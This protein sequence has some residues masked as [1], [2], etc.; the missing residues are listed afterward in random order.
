MAFSSDTTTT[1]AQKEKGRIINVTHQ[2]PYEISLK[3]GSWQYLPR[4]GHG[5]MYGGI[6]SLQKSWDIVY[7]GWTGLINNIVDKKEFEAYSTKEPVQNLSKAE[8]ATLYNQ[9]EENYS[10]IPL[11]FDSQSVSGH[12]DGYCKTSKLFELYMSRIN[13]KIL[14]YMI[15]LWP[16]FHYMIWNDATDGRLESKQWE[17]YAAVNQRYADFVSEMY[18]D[19]DTSKVVFYCTTC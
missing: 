15:V 7:I 12:Y 4:R 17:A 2:I 10:C 1:I 16:L 14:T 18:K 11:F 13:F 3:E 5:A 9:L 6:H 19:G 8:K